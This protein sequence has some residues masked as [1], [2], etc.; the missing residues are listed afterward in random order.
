MSND[1][2]KE[3]LPDGGYARTAIKEGTDQIKDFAENAQKQFKEGQEQIGKALSTVDKQVRENPWP[4]VAGVA[5]GSF[6]IGVL[7][8]KSNK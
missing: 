5:I 6:L 1:F 7:L 8:S 4:V 2:N 3:K